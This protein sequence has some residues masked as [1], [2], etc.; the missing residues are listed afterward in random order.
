MGIEKAASEAVAN[1]VKSAATGLANNNNNAPNPE[2]QAAIPQR[3]RMRGR[4]EFWD[5]RWIC[6]KND[7]SHFVRRICFNEYWLGNSRKFAFGL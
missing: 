6:H 1:A 4:V 5:S 2:Q 3:A 7:Q